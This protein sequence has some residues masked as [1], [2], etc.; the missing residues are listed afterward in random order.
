MSATRALAAA[1]A[2]GGLLL[3]SAPAHAD[4]V[5]DFYRG[6]RLTMLIGYGGGSLYDLYARLLIRYLP[7]HIPGRPT[8]VPENMPGASSLSA[9]NYLFNVAKR[10]GS[11]IGAFHERMG[12]EPRV[13]PKGTRYDGRAFNWIGSMQRQVS[14]CLTWA[15]SGIRTVEDMKRREVI[16]GGSDVAGSSAVFPRLMNS[17]L[18]TRIRLVTGYDASQIDLALERGEV[19]ARCGA[20]WAGIKVQHP[21]WIRQHKIAIPV[22]FSLRPHP[23]LPEVPTLYALVSDASERQALEVMFATAEMGKPYAMPPGVPP[24][25]VAALRQAFD[26]AMLDKDLIA[27]AE[28]SQLELG[29]LSGA[30]IEE[31]LVRLY[32]L[33]DAIFRKLAAWRSP[34]AES[35]SR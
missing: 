18:G 16:A 25:R 6:R 21:D 8:I 35:G 13:E 11:V 7:R 15:A 23:E 24:E 31:M 34:P 4:P 10:D 27:E 2:L 28:Q 17:L 3:A 33:P 9:T 5:E 19:E 32:D 12:L 14:V 1:L 29:A 20:G 26:R 22:Q 30:A